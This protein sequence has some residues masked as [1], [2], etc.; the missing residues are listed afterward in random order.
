MI[1]F[2]MKLALARLNSE[3]EKWELLHC[4]F[5]KD[6]FVHLNDR[7][8]EREAET[9]IDLPSGGSTPVIASGKTGAK[10]S[11]WCQGPKHL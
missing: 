7:V 6:L 3:F 2:E 9:E 8:A 11:H 10:I 5:E 4:F 1:F